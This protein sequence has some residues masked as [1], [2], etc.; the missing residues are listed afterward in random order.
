MNEP[1][2]IDASVALREK[3]V[4]ILCFIGNKQPRTKFIKLNN[5]KYTTR[6]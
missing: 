4:L 6:K 3:Y 5:D 2:R 1:T